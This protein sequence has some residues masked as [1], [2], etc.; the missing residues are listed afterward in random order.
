M[1]SRLPNHDRVI[2]SLRLMIL[3]LFAADVYDAVIVW[4]TA[5]WY[6]VERTFVHQWFQWFLYLKPGHFHCGPKIT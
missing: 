1:W 2:S 4:M 3:R 6:Q 5:R